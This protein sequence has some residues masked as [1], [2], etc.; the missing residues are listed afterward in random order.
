MLKLNMGPN[1]LHLVCSAQYHKAGLFDHEGKKL[2]SYD[3]LCDGQHSNWHI[4]RGD[5]PPGTYKAG[6]VY[7]QSFANLPELHSYG[8]ICIDL[9]DLENQETGNGRSGISLHGGGTGLPNPLALMQELIAT[10]GCLRFHNQDLEEDIAPRVTKCQKA[11][12]TFYISVTD[13]V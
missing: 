11:G 13:R 8:F 12:G 9:I 10:L 7:H 5:T 2:A 6:I 1:D 3:C 4:A